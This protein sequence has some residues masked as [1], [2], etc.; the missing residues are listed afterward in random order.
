MRSANNY[1]EQKLSREIICLH[2][3]YPV[4]CDR[5]PAKLPQCGT[6]KTPAASQRNPDAPAEEAE[7]QPEPAQEEVV[8]EPVQ[9]MEAPEPVAPP[10]EEALAEETPAEEAEP[11]EAVAAEE[12]VE[13]KAPPQEGEMPPDE[14]ARLLAEPRD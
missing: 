10:V 7:L 12:P 6:A 5:M 8:A 11:Q 2:A 13:E 9:E 4:V 1:H 3:L 14:V